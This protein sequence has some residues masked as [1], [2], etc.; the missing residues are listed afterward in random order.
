[1]VG[2]LAADGV[3][4]EAADGVLAEAA[5]GVLAEAADASARLRCAAASV[6]RSRPTPPTALHV[7]K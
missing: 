1:V 4:A 5:D 2:V 6:P 3:L 7:H